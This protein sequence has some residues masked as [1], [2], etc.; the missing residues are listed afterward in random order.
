MAFSNL[1]DKKFLDASGT[2]HLWDKIKQR[3]DSKLDEV[4]AKDDSITISNS[5]EIKVHISA[6]PGNLLELKTT[7][8][9]GL[10]VSGAGG[11]GGSTDT[12]TIEKASNSGDYA[13]IYSLMKYASGSQSG[14]KMGV[15][16]NIPKDMVVQSGTV[17]TKSTS[18]VWGPAGTYIHLV[19][20]NA[21]S[22]DLYINVSTLIEDITSGSQPGDMV[23]ISINASTH[24]ITASI[25]DD[26]ITSDKLHPNVRASLNLAATSV[27]LITE[28]STDG[29]IDVDGNEIAV[30]GLGSAAFMDDTDFDEAGAAAD[31]LGTSS[32]TAS[33]MTVYG[34]KQYASDAYDAIIALTNAEIDAAIVAAETT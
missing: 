17:E 34:V 28:G 2:G 30:H 31:V 21:D 13:A 23:V 26:T 7:G 19:L 18:G 14:T 10:Y 12:Y 9:K 3:Y 22:S 29:T 1:T 15:D 8:N 27:Q 5:N 33:T 16:I 20:A 32:D 25:T 11:G 4:T 6:E 24:Q